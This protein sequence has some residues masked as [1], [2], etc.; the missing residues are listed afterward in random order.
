MVSWPQGPGVQVWSEGRDQAPEPQPILQRLVRLPA[1]VLAT[2]GKG[3]GGPNHLCDLRSPEGRASLTIS[4]GGARAA[5]IPPQSLTQDYG[6]P[7]SPN[8]PP[9]PL[10]SPLR[11]LPGSQ[12]PGPGAS[13]ISA[14][15]E[16]PAALGE[17]W[18]ILAS[19]HRCFSQNFR[20]RKNSQTLPSQWFHGN[21]PS[22]EA[23]SQSPLPLHPL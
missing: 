16:D 7:A 1:S 21:S 19:G 9:R 12:Q 3:I 6:S 14:L 5:P 22:Y 4:V 23:D 2:L 15:R 10:P 13:R 8:H 20:V 17:L 18:L 11:V